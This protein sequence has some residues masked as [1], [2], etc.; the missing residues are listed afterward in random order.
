MLA[1]SSAKK[2][3]T[4]WGDLEDPS[5]PY[6]SNYY[7]EDKGCWIFFRHERIIIPPEKGPATSAFAVS[8]KGE[9]SQRIFENNVRS[10]YKTW[11]VIKKSKL[12]KILSLSKTKSGR[13]TNKAG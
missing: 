7:M 9:I 1:E 5:P 11:V 8:K 3:I 12:T 4:V 13:V 10:F 6:L 2:L